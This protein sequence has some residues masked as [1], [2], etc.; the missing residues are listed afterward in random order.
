[1]QL[2]DGGGGNCFYPVYFEVLK[3]TCATFKENGRDS[4]MHSVLIQF[5]HGVSVLSYF[6]LRCLRNFSLV[7][8][9]SL[10]IAL[11]NPGLTSFRDELVSLP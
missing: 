9:A 4:C 1:M 8:P 11:T 6:S 10:I 2:S 7:I 5:I 3:G